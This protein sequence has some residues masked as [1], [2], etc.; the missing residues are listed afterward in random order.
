MSLARSLKMVFWKIKWKKSSLININSINYYYV[1]CVNYVNYFSILVYFHF[2]QVYN[3]NLVK[4]I[5]YLVNKIIIYI[6]CVCPATS[7]ASC[8]WRWYRTR[9]IS[10]HI[11]WVPSPSLPLRGRRRRRF[12]SAES[13]TNRLHF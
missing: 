1:N 6:F 2:S 12:R 4:D 11:F 9:P 10:V 8:Q 13:G 7:W 3:K 5:I